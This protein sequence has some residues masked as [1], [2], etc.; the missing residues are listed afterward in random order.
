MDFSGL[1]HHLAA[2]PF[3]ATLVIYL[4]G[5]M[6]SM[7]PCVYPMIPITAAIIGGQSVGARSRPRI[8]LL[9]GAYVTGLSAVYSVLGVFA[10]LSGTLFGSVS[11]NPWLYLLMANILIVAALVML[12]VIPVRLPAFL[13][14]S[15]AAGKGGSVPG[16]F[17]MGAVSG[18]V[19]A[20][21]SAP[22]M[23]IVLTWVATT[24]SGALGF[25]YL[26]AFSLG[27]CTLL[28]AVGLSAGTLA[29]LP[30]AGLWMVWIRR[31]FAA[32]MIG[33]AEYYL[34]QMGQLLI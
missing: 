7:A 27:M 12:G 20:P 5:V 11:T 1:P 8:A 23:A 22:V 33:V 34:M 26:L 31:V 28:V 9:V 18:L 10:G 25:I 14:R 2:N 32:I 16:T 19:A 6:A 13:G 29:S 3:L 4:G 30:R 21:C 24:G 15:A 17:T